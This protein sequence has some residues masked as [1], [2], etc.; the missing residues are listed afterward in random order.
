M[1]SSILVVVKINVESLFILK[2]YYN[3]IVS[4]IYNISIQNL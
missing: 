4:L 3:Y 1:K 2:L